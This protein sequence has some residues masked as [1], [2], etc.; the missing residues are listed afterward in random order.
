MGHGVGYRCGTHT[1]WD[2]G[3]TYGVRWKSGTHTKRDSHGEGHTEW[4]THRVGYTHGG[5]LTV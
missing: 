2:I 4:D 1:E 5:A 3:D